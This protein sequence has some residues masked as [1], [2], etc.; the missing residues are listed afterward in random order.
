MVLKKLSRSPT[1]PEALLLVCRKYKR[2]LATTF[3]VQTLE[4]T[5]KRLPWVV[6]VLRHILS[7]QT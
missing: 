2:I 6:G 5:Q 1:I 4:R 7:L 3:Q